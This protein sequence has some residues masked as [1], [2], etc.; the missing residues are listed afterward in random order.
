M[1]RFDHLRRHGVHLGLWSGGWDGIKSIA[2]GAWDAIT[3]GV[4]GALDGVSNLFRGAVDGIGRIWGNITEAV[5]GPVR[6]VL[7]FIRDK[8]VGPINS[9]M[10]T[11]GASPID[12]QVPQ[13]HTGGYTGDKPGRPRGFGAAAQRRICNES[14]GHRPV[15][16]HLGG[17]E[18]R[19]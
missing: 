13:F 2:S 4:R 8:M 14:A 5:K 16:A 1:G 7:E 6:G 11:V 19:R 12:F 3:N 9:I 10:S 17:A 18:R 15:P